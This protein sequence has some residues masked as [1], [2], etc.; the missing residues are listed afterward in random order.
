LAAVAVCVC[1]FASAPRQAGAAEI[2][3]AGGGDG[4][5]G[6]LVIE[7]AIAPGDFDEVIRLLRA[8]EATIAEVSLFSRGGDFAEAMRIGRALRTLELSSRVPGR[9]TAG[10]PACDTP[11]VEPRDRSNCTCASACFFAHI[12]A[13]R[14]AGGYLAVHRPYFPRGEFGRLPQRDAMRTFAELQRLAARYMEEMGVPTHVQ[15]DVLGT[16]S[17]RTLV[18]D[19]R[20]VATWFSGDVPYR[21]EW[22]RNR[23]AQ[24]TRFDCAAAVDEEHRLAAYAKYFGAKPA[25]PRHP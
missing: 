2:R 6:V 4:A 8:H 12:G 21:D 13:A 18:L 17:N 25:R 22:I 16:P 20:T 19:E 1:V 10:G 24:Q 7:G 15:D 5:A 9:T 23:C 14:R 3:V 11:G